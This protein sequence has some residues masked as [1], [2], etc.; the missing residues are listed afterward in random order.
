[1]SLK[2]GKVTVACRIPS[3]IGA[4]AEENMCQRLC[5]VSAKNATQTV[6]RITII[7]ED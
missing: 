6:H 2:E 7:K 1:M 3:Y 5:S 4:I